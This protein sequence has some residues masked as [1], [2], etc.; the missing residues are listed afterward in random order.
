MSETA[1]DDYGVTVYTVHIIQ[2]FMLG[3]AFG[4]LLISKYSDK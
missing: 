1:S 3:H 2:G 4:S